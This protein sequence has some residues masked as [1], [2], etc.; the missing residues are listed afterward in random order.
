MENRYQINNSPEL[1]DIF[2]R[3]GEQ[4]RGENRLSAEQK[5]A[6]R[7]IQQCRTEVLGGRV[8]QCDKCGFKANLYNSCRNRHCPKCQTMVKEKWLHDRRSELLPCSYFHC[9]F[10]LTHDLNPLI[11]YNR[12]LCFNILFAAI[13]ETFKTFASDPQWRLVGEVGFIAILH[14]W[15]QLLIDHFHVHCIVPAGVLSAS[16]GWLPARSNYLFRVQSMAKRFKKL[17]LKKFKNAYDKNELVLPDDFTHL[18]NPKQFEIFIRRLLRKNWRAYVKPPFRD[19]E[20]V[21]QYLGRYTHRVAISNNR[22]KDIDNDQVTFTYRDRQDN[23]K[24]KDM[25]LEVQEFI[26]RFLLHILPSSFVKIRYFGF[27]AHTKKREC[28]ALIR[29]LLDPY[30]AAPMKIKETLRE[31]MLRLTGIDINCCPQCGKGKMVIVEVLNSSISQ[32]GWD[33]S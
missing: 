8:E 7:H 6:M 17:F 20:D 13:N 19:P 12:R 30:A 21:L 16:K 27:L 14:T 23:N 2:R 11:L 25:T 5:K 24:I 15:S 18:L 28:I 31:M 3:Y 33:S 10:T 32:T 9:V 4:Y 22:I 26:R 1:A 29:K